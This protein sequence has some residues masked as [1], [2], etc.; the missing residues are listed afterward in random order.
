MFILSSS[1]SG[2]TYDFSIYQT[3]ENDN[4]IHAKKIPQKKVILRTGEHMSASNIEE[5]LNWKYLHAI[6]QK[7]ALTSIG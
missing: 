3:I 1:S 5:T 7:K 2:H 4:L 6:C